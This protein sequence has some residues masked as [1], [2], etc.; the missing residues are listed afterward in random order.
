MSIISNSFK[1]NAGI[2]LAKSMGIEDEA[3]IEKIVESW[4]R[5]FEIAESLFTEQN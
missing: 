2:K 1:R 4:T 5:G 3:M